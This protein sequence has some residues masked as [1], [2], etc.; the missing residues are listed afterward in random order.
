[1]SSSYGLTA[2]D[3]QEDIL[4]YWLGRRK[5]GRWAAATCALAVPRQNGKN[6]IIEV[7][8]LFGMVALGEKFLHTAHEV[9]TA[10]KAFLRIASF[11]ENTRKHPELAELAREIRKTNGQEAIF[12]NNGGS[13]EFIARS[14]GSGRGFTVDVLV[15]DEA[16]DLADEELA[17]LLPTISAA[18]SGNPQV[19]LT[20][21]PPDPDKPGHGVVFSRVRKDGMSKADPRLCWDDFGIADGPIGRV[22]LDNRETWADCNPTLGIRLAVEEVE[23]ER[24]LMSP[25]D[26]ASE[27]LGWWGEGGD[28]GGAIPYAAWLGLAD[29]EAGRGAGPIFGLDVA[30]DRTGW[31]AVAWT[32]PDGDVQVMLANEGEPL[33]AYRVAAEGAR[34]STSWSARVLAPRGFVPELRRAGATVEQFDSADFAAACGAFA[35]A[36]K[37]GTIHHGDQPLLNAAVKAAVWRS[38]GTDG[39]RAFQL[40]D[41]PAA[42]PLA[43]AVRAVRGLKPSEAGVWGWDDIDSS[44]ERSSE[45][46]A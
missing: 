2:D 21:T 27:R 1:L 6:G 5:D 8:E 32:R 33:P 23:R 19:I 40:R 45:E 17:A 25:E 4:G 9:K 10:R 30:E 22:D 13:I 15:C 31:F 35:D 28:R 16:Q 39:S 42:G 46:D 11:F 43:A 7:R 20:G 26:F 24:A 38:A 29:A 44:D 3:W 37:A 36:V 14:R 34:L 41:L 12:L 18:P